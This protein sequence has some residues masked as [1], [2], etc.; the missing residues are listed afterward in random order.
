MYMADISGSKR[1]FIFEWRTALLTVL[2]LPLMVTLGFWQLQRADKKR[3]IQAAYELQ[4]ARPAMD[5]IN[6]NMG[7]P[8]ALHY[9]PVLLQ[10]EWQQQSFLLDNQRLQG[11]MGYNVI[12]VLRLMD[13]RR[14]LVNRGWVI[15]PR[16]RSLLPTWSPPVVGAVERGEVYAIQDWLADGNVY[17]EPGWPRRIERLHAKALARELEVDILPVMVRLQAGSSSALTVNWPVV[18]VSP[19]KHVAYAVQWFCMAV[20]LLI[21]YLV[22][23]FR[24]VDAVSENKN[25][26]DNENIK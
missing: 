8:Q 10:G 26:S 2:L 4:Q 19:L 15:A 21:F 17:A 24:R 14:V 1:S 13:G 9:Q 25:L 16:L 23:S 12:G 3:E 5:L 18:N 22:F 6:L 11:R 7:E 20:A